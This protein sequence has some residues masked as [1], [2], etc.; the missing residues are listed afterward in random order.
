M[1]VLGPRLHHLGQGFLCLSREARREGEG[2][3]RE[4]AA[5]AS[6][7]RRSGGSVRGWHPPEQPLDSC[8]AFPPPLLPRIAVAAQAAQPLQQS[9]G[10]SLPGGPERGGEERGGGG[11]EGRGVGVGTGPGG[12]GAGVLFPFFFSRFFF[13]A[14]VT[15]GRGSRFRS[16]CFPFLPSRNLNYLDGLLAVADSQERRGA[17]GRG[18][19]AAGFLLSLSLLLLLPLL[20]RRRR[21]RRKRLGEREREHR[22]SQL[23]AQRRDPLERD[24]QGLLEPLSPH[25]SAAGEPAER[26]ALPR[27]SQRS[28]ASAS[29]TRSAA[30]LARAEGEGSG[31]EGEEAGLSTPS[32]GEEGEKEEPCSC[33]CGGEAEEEA[34]GGGGGGKVAA[35]IAF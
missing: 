4:I 15:K 20:R 19:A 8:R 32:S 23:L 10:V 9:L 2:G 7:G 35:A 24:L 28:G 1:V 3:S 13:R 34:S 29:A 31:S 17:Q 26:P 5:A 21:R 11:A 25:H 18:E 14:G 33:F 30:V 27:G 22:S 6:F 12:G 16:L